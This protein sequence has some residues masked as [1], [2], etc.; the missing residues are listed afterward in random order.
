MVY[1]KNE[2]EHIIK[3][4]KLTMIDHS[5]WNQ[6]RFNNFNAYFRVD[7]PR[8]F[9]QQFRKATQSELVWNI[10]KGSGL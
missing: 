10:E 8:Y 9:S 3:L 7:N 6:N 1:F 2:Y 5:K 4:A